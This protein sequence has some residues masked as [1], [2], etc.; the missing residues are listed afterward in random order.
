M[1]IAGPYI[2][3]EKDRNEKVNSSTPG[4]ALRFDIY[5]YYE[6]RGHNIYLGEDVELKRLG[7][8]Q[9]GANN[10]AV[11]FERDYIQKNIDVLIVIPDGPGVFCEFGDWAST[12]DT[13]KKMLVIIDKRYEGEASYIND[14]TAKAAKYHGATIV[15]EDYNDFNSVAKACDEFIDLK[16][17][18]LRIKDLYGRR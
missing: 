3:R 9:Y 2:E 15:Y 13:S 10:N 17:S 1:F 8:A 6:K 4:K 12:E 14:G 16:A 11:F 18:A 7:Q 5:S